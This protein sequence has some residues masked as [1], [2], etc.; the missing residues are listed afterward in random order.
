MS[1]SLT[2]STTIEEVIHKYIATVSDKFNI[3][4][5][6]LYS[7]W[8]GK[9]G[10]GP[11]RTEAHIN[12][13]I[14][15]VKKAR[16]VKSDSKTP[17]PID[18]GV[19]LKCNKAELIALCKTHGH[20]CSGTKEALVSR[21][22]GKVDSSTP[23]SKKKPSST[24]TK[25]ST[26]KA[27]PVIKN[28]VANIPNILIRRNQHNNYEHPETGLVFNN[29]T[30]VVI[31]KQNDNGSIDQLTENDIDQCNAFKFKFEIPLDLD[32]KSNLNDVKVDELEEGEETEE[33]EE[34]E[35]AEE[36]LEEDDLE[37]VEEEEELNDEDFEDDELLGDD[38][39][40]V[41][42]E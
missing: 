30:K 35:E 22:L 13:Q 8:Q 29:A 37:I 5:D 3:N 41:T 17:E 14:Q 42:D 19:L 24:T 39:E 21:L 25:V 4:Q 36:D 9:P 2:L 23:A 1:L 6:E 32:S 12:K 16:E 27:T 38:E 15:E 20:K 10:T 34:T 7:I 28:L 40:Y 26:T 11:N 31:G 18:P 33:T